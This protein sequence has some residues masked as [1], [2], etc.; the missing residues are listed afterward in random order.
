MRFKDL[1]EASDDDLDNSSK[2]NIDAIVLSVLITVKDNIKNKNLKN[3]VKLGT[4][5]TLI[6]NAAKLQY[7]KNDLIDANARNES[8]GN[9]IKNISPE[10]VEFKVGEDETNQEEL[11]APPLTDPTEVVGN[12][13]K[14][15]MKR[16]Q[17]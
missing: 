14:S 9:I 13:A 2:S 8:I 3:E 5:L 16:R 4:I 12:M 6:S 15:A 11:D 10:T 7:T 1:I 17:D